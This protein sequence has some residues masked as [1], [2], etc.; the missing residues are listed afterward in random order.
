MQRHNRFSAF[1]L[2]LMVWA[3]AQLGLVPASSARVPRSL[4]GGDLLTSD[5]LRVDGRL[6]RAEI[7]TGHRHDKR[8]F[9]D[10]A[11]VLTVSGGA[12][13][14][15]SIDYCSAYAGGWVKLY[16]DVKG[17]VYLFHGVFTG[18]GTSVRSESADVYRL[19]ARLE[20]LDVILLEAFATALETYRY[21]Y[22]VATPPEGGLVVETSLILP[23]NQQGCCEDLPRHERFRFGPEG[24]QPESPSR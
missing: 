16:V 24:K 20:H 5:E 1:S 17:N 8:C 22:R 9:A 18:R 4:E 23:K 6:V 14:P 21:T 13:G 15:V 2:F 11:W 7:K 12:S 3:S 19:G 10:D